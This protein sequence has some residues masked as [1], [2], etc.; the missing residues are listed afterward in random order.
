M[1]VGN[2]RTFLL[3]EVSRVKQGGVDVAW[4]L[5]LWFWGVT[6]EWISSI[7]DMYDVFWIALLS[8]FS[9][10]YDIIDCVELVVHDVWFAQD[11][12]TGLL[13]VGLDIFDQLY[14]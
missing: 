3:I 13:S 10:W 11:D 9:R 8:L 7:F 12:N 1:Y 14:L 6:Q 5:I 4:T 2:V